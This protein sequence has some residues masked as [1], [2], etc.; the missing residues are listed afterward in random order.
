ME[1]GGSILQDL[2]I[3]CYSGIWGLESDWSY[4]F[5]DYTLILYPRSL[6]TITAAK[7]TV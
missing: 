2:N 7:E 1:R 6:V 4:S 3:L 5:Q